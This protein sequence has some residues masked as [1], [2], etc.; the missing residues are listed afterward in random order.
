MQLLQIE[1]L[2]HISSRVISN[3][4]YQKNF[5]FT[6]AT[7]INILHHS[8]LVKQQ[9]QNFQVLMKLILGL[10]FLSVLSIS[11]A[12]LSKFCSAMDL[13]NFCYSITLHQKLSTYS[14]EQA[15]NIMKESANRLRDII[16]KEK[17]ENIEIDEKGNAIAK[18]TVTVDGTWKHW[19]ISKIGIVFVILVPAGE[20]LDFIVKSLVCHK[21]MKLSKLSKK[22][23]EKHLNA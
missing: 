7:V 1:A 8:V 21:C 23:S 22:N 17:P 10:F 9:I 13:P 3:M 6:G 20:V 11:C 18:V 15:N 16:A 4:V 2:H 19:H 14:V 5:Y 12:G